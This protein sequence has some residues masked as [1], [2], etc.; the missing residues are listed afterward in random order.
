MALYPVILAGGSGTRLWPL[1]RELYPKQFLTLLGQ[2]SLLQET[3]FRLDG[4]EHIAPPIIVCNEEHRFLVAEHTRQM[5]ITP[6]SIILESEGRNTAPALTLAALYLADSS[7]NLDDTDPVMLVMPADHVLRD[8]Q[9]FQT[10]VQKGA[11]LAQTGFLVT[12]GIV[13]I[14][15]K[16]GYGYIKK[17]EIIELP[18]SG[19][20]LR[21]HENER[22]SG[23]STIP[24]RIDAF[25]E[26]PDEAEA[27]KMLDSGDYLWNSG[28]FMMRASVWLEQLE[29]H[30]PDIAEVCQI[31]Y[32]N[33][34]SDRDFYRPDPDAF[35]SCPSDSIDYAV[36]EKVAGYSNGNGFSAHG[37]ASQPGGVVLPLEA[38]WSDIGAW[39]ALWEES[40][41]DSQ[42]NVIRGDVYARSTCKSLLIA[43]H[44]ML[45]AVGLENVIVVETADAVLVAHKDMVHDVKAIV[46][47]LK[48]E[49]R[50]EQ[51]THR[52]VH[53]PWGSYEAVDVGPRFQV[54]R[55]TVNPGAALSLQM[56][57]HR[58][59][60][61]V[62]VR[63]VA[64]VTKGEVEFLLAE[65]E[66]T[67]VPVG[68]KH[69]LE[70]PGTIPLEIIEVQ[71]GDYLGEDDIVRFADRYNR[72]KSH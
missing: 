21:N 51:Q 65:N 10:V 14:S 15:P 33:G 69:R 2:R 38:G 23:K 4:I 7:R 67:D 61:W 1:S 5:N 64:K 53:R 58:A 31:A 62:V 8:V 17:G 35:I 52:K 48:A 46:E 49:Q 18:H 40:E 54:K 30:R 50:S 29:R 45:A 12:F 56:H 9:S 71:S 13:P 22:G 26:K 57:H 55:L 32:E 44:R 6:A 63:G 43:E 34:V 36:M 66:S 11:A 59:E 72:V 28:I 47:Q 24:C 39:S 37:S 20:L 68:M 70:N 19:E 3:I 41:Q 42:G 60:H 25:V 27:K 16:T